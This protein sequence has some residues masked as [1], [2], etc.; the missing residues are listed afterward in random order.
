M[1]SELALTRHMSHLRAT[2]FVHELFDLLYVIAI[3][4]ENKKCVEMICLK[5]RMSQ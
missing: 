2:P 5:I 4:Q 3:K 1:E